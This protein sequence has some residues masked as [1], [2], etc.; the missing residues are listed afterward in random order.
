[1]KT[2]ILIL[3]TTITFRIEVFA[4]ECNRL[5]W[6]EWD[7]EEVKNSM[8]FNE[9]IFIGEL[10]SVKKAHY[11]FKVLNVFKGK[12]K[13]NDI[14]KG[15][16]VTSCSGWPSDKRTGEWIF[17]GFYEQD[18][19]GRKVLNYSQCGP[20]RSLNYPIYTKRQNIKNWNTELEMLNEKF[21]KN[22]ELKLIT[23]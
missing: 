22:V 16:Y 3:L 18:Q 13:E 17:Y 11:E 5:I 7:K 9:V 2:T 14:I 1:M 8:E 12:L 4:C 10:V 21:N 19:N 6:S 20:T 23:E 15:F